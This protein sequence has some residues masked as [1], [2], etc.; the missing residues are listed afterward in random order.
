MR[1]LRIYR[2][3]GVFNHADPPKERKKPDAL[4]HCRK[5]MVWA[6][7][8]QLRGNN[9]KEIL[10]LSH[11][12]ISK[13]ITKFGGQPVWINQAQWPISKKTEKPMM[14]IGQIKLEPG[15]FGR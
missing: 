10:K 12:P 1:N 2:E 14:F 4:S 3:Q 13:P 8:R 9:E 6:I 15:L 5:D 11:S 7:R